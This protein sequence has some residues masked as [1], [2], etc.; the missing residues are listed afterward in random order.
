MKKPTTEHTDAE[1]ELLDSISHKREMARRADVTEKNLMRRDL[2]YYNGHFLSHIDKITGRYSSVS[3]DVFLRALHDSNKSVVFINKLRPAVNV[4]KK[5]FIERKPAMYVVVNSNDERVKDAAKMG[6][7]LLKSYHQTKRGATLLDHRVTW[8]LV[9]GKA[10]RWFH[11]VITKYDAFGSPAS[12]EVVETVLSPWEVSVAPGTRYTNDSPWLIIHRYEDR[13]SIENWFDIELDESK[14]Q[15]YGED[16]YSLLSGDKRGDTELLVNY[17]EKPSRRNPRGRHVIVCKDMILKDGEHPYWDDAGTENERWGGYRVIPY[18]FHD[19]LYTYWSRGLV[20]G[21]VNINMKINELM[22]CWMTNRLNTMGLKMYIDSRTK[23]SQKDT[24]NLPGIVTLASGAKMPE[25]PR[26]PTLPTDIQALLQELNN[27]FDEEAGIHSL[28]RGNEP[29]QRM[30][31][32]AV[33]HLTGLDIQKY[34][35]VYYRFEEADAESAKV[36]LNSIK[37]FCPDMLFYQFGEDRHGQARNFIADSLSDFEVMYERGSSIPESAAG[38][39]SL[40]SDLATQGAVTLEDRFTRLNYLQAMKV[41]WASDFIADE[42][43]TKSFAEEENRIMLDGGVVMP[44]PMQ[45]HDMHSFIHRKIFDSTTYLKIR[46]TPIEQIVQAHL[47]MHEQFVAQAQMAMMPPQGA[48]AGSPET[49]APPFDPNLTPVPPPAMPMPTGPPGE[50][51]FPPAVAG[52]PGA[53]PTDAERALLMEA[54]GNG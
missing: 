37:Q 20:R 21:L 46:G 5:H 16:D 39:V 43:S 52:G 3:M 29:E 51:V 34:E 26:L 7:D 9:C 31:Y 1:R 18:D 13:T 23:L 38:R 27:G 36:Y 41:P 42:L 8:T 32:Q 22:S 24:D 10:H 49:M 47:G 15:S 17:F 19:T 11:P 44:H 25:Y 30:P 40:M 28:S 12:S 48:E 53:G 45:D 50:A 4:V 14:T 54:L 35:S 33:A 2:D 6:T